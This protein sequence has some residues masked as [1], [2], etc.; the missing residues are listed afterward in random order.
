MVT[1]N[2]FKQ[3]IPVLEVY[4]EENFSATLAHNKSLVVFKDYLETSTGHRKHAL[5]LP[6]RAEVRRRVEKPGQAMNSLQFL[7]KFVVKSSLLFS[8]LNGGKGT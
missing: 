1:E 8:S 3:F 2:K 7:L 6:L 5:P 4:I